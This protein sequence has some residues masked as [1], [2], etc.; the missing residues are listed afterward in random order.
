MPNWLIFFTIFSS[1]NPRRMAG[2]ILKGVLMGWLVG[3]LIG[4]SLL[5]FILLRA[6]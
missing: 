4:L 2:R 6:H 5:A 1:A 3:F